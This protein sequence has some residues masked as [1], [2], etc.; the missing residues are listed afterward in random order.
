MTVRTLLVHEGRGTGYKSVPDPSD[1]HHHVVEGEPP[2]RGVGR[3][4]CVCGW[5]KTSGCGVCLNGDFVAH[6]EAERAK[7]ADEAN[8][9]VEGW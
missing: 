6:V 7:R 2:P 9:Y 3:R 5:S 4:S 1:E 8:T